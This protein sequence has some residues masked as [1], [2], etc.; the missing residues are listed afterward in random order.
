MVDSAWHASSGLALQIAER[1]DEIAD[2]IEY[3]DSIEDRCKAWRSSKH[4]E[5]E[6]S[7]I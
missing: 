6:D 7:G 1:K 5:Q 3:T 4:G 2:L